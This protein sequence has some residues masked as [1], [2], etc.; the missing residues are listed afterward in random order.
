ME[1]EFNEKVKD[2][3]RRLLPSWMTMSIRMKRVLTAT[4][5]DKAESQYLIILTN[6]KSSG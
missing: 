3:E 6:L 1:F 5:G 4:G 2:F